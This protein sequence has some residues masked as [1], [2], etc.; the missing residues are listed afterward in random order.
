MILG[1]DASN[2]RAGGGVAHLQNLLHAAQPEHFGI[3]K[4]IIWGGRTPLENLPQ[5]NWLELHK[6]AALN[7][8]LCYRLGWQQFRLA[9]LAEGVCDLLFVP[10]G[11]YL[12]NF[13]PYVTMFQNMQ[14]FETSELNREGVSKE[15]VRFRLLKAA[16]SLTF[17]RSQGLICLSEYSMN[18]LKLFYPKLLNDVPTK[19]TRP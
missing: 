17:R 16:Q 12:G 8:A 6:V 4:V 11:L 18:Y 1:I 19:I 13:R 7:S 14:V 15:M 5:Y 2:I 3:E 9:E 10:G